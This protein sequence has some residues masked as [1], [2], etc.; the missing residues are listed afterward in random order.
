MRYALVTFITFLFLSLPSA[1]TAAGNAL[2]EVKTATAGI[3]TQTNS[4]LSDAS[5]SER[6]VKRRAAR[7]ERDVLRAYLACP[8]KMNKAAPRLQH[9]DR[10][11]HRYLE[12]LGSVLASTDPLHAFCR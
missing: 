10:L 6:K 8:Q 3:K 9:A 2:F 5:P 7:I 1:S 4:V 11:L 12:D